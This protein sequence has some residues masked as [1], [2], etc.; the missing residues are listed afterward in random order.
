MRMV[1]RSRLVWTHIV[2]ADHRKHPLHSARVCH[3][4]VISLVSTG[5][6]RSALALSS[7]TARTPSRAIS[8]SSAAT[9]CACRPTLGLSLTSRSRSTTSS[10]TR[11][12]ACSRN[13]APSRS[14]PGAHT[15]PGARSRTN[16]RCSSW[17]GTLASMHAVLGSSPSTVSAVSCT[18][19]A[20]SA[21]RMVGV[22]GKVGSHGKVGRNALSCRE[23]PGGG[24]AYTGHNR[25][26]DSW[27]MSSHPQR[28]VSPRLRGHCKHTRR[29]Q[30]CR[31]QS[32]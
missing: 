1:V 23:S 14:R 13:T 9:A 28:P 11:S 7:S 22:M 20:I 8:A 17:R 10:H 18:I 32:R 5:R 2:V 19:P 31:H 26:C 6:T 15:R 27:N 4:N 16:T 30:R 25:L 3:A 21:S 29:H 24:R 12:A